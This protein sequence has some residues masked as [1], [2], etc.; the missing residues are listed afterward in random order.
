MAPSSHQIVVISSSVDIQFAGRLA[1]DLSSRGLLVLDATRAELDHPE[2]GLPHGYSDG[3]LLLVLSGDGLRSAWLE[4]EIANA[5]ALAAAHPALILIPI[6]ITPDLEL[7]PALAHVTPLDFAGRD[8]D[9][10]L[11]DLLARLSPD[12]PAALNGA[13]ATP[14]EPERPPLTESAPRSGPLS[15]QQLEE[16]KR[17]RHESLDRPSAVASPPA[18]APAQAPS[19]DGLRSMLAETEH[20]LWSKDDDTEQG[21]EPESEPAASFGAV[22]PAP[23]SEEALPAAEP[24][25]APAPEVAKSAAPAPEPVPPPAQMAEPAAPPPPPSPA[26]APAPAPGWAAAPTAEP[27][28]PPAPAPVA[29]SPAPVAASAGETLADLVAGIPAFPFADEVEAA[30]EPEP[31]TQITASRFL[32]VEPAPAVAVPEEVAFTAFHPREVDPKLWQEM[33]IYIAADTPSSLATVAADAEARLA[34]RKGGYR[35]A[36]TRSTAPLLRGTQLTIVPDLPGFDFNPTS[37]TVAWEE[38]AQRHE[39]RLRSA[40]ARPG[41]AAN[42]SVRIYAGPYLRGEIPIS[43]FVQDPQARIK[44]PGGVIS[45]FARAYHKIFASYSHKDTEVVRTCEAA[46]EA[47]GDRYLRDVTLLRSGE[48]WNERLLQ[49]IDEADIFQLFWSEQSAKSFAVEK[50]WRHALALASTRPGFIRPVYWSGKPYH[51][52]AELSP[53]HF[54]RLDLSRLSVRANRSLVGRLLGR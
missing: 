19:D 21:D 51:I 2:H 32:R 25:S 42:G 4:H 49:A 5:L 23:A 8:Y 45:V 26:P 54:D 24:L 35:D 34:S 29:A 48:N 37:L 31:E 11:A 43:I 50:E 6:T 16:L 7:P 47:L 39:F 18:P 1:D 10:A 36:T 33:L 52:P 9:D 15:W 27:A 40:S 38:D 3:A 41:Q 46:T 20:M 53:I 12:E 30:S 22:T 14:V 44:T 17:S 28:P 13:H